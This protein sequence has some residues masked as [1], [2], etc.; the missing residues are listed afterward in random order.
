M[1]TKTSPS[2]TFVIGPRRYKVR[3]DSKVSLKDAGFVG[4]TAIYLSADLP[5]TWRLPVLL[6]EL[7]MLCTECYGPCTSDHSLEATRFGNF[8]ADI[9]R[10]LT[11]QGG[12]AVLQRLKAE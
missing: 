7:W 5:P 6:R 9:I 8:A 10:Q 11:D 12:E 2:L 4:F 3:V 1:K